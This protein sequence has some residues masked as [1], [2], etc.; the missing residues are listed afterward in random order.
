MNPTTDKKQRQY[1]EGIFAIAA[2]LDQSGLLRNTIYC[3]E[4]TIFIMNGDNTVLLKFNL[5]KHI[6]EFHEP[7]SFKANDYESGKLYE[8]DGHV[9]F[10]LEGK[11]DD[12]FTRLKTCKTPGLSFNDVISFLQESNTKKTIKAVLI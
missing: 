12:E 6:S 1:L 3:F 10:Q 4:K 9:C 5:P 2:A 11:S 8:K 7:I